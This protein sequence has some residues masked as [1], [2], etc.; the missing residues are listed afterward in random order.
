MSILTFVLNVSASL[1][2]TEQV[3]FTS[4]LS[5][6]VGMGTTGYENLGRLKQQERRKGEIQDEVLA[7]GGGWLPTQCE[8]GR[9]G[10]VKEA[11]RH[12]VI[13]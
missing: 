12:E 2:A 9:Q 3:A 5:M 11:L 6:T 4:P 7:D 1:V 10:P 13:R 8:K